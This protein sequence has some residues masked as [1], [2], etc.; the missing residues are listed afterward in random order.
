[1]PCFKITEDDNFISFMDIF[2]PRFNGKIT[3]P[4]VLISSKKHLGSNVFEDLNE[5]EYVSF[6]RFI[7]KIA[8][9]IQ[10]ALDPERVCLVFEG[11]EIDHLHAKLYPISKRNYPGYLSTR[12]S[13]NNKSVRASDK[14]L[15]DQADRIKKKL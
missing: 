3:M 6:S 7:R 1:M 11:M 13:S 14:Y 12:K 15:K 2:P 4:V 5:K 8:K 10:K 9:V